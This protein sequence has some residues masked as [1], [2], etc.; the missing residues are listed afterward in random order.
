MKTFSINKDIS[1][2]G[3]Q[4]HSFPN[5]VNQAWENLHKLLPGVNRRTLYGVSHGTRHGEIVYYACV[6]EAFPGEAAQVGGEAIV[7][8][9]G[10]YIGD[11]VQ[12]FTTQPQKI[13]ETFQTILRRDDYDTDACCV[14]WYKNEGEVVC[15]IKSKQD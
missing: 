12:D 4:A 3:V 9:K 13:G 2:F 1:V 10:E 7:L 14:E 11:V 5:G 15:M 6:E 8:P